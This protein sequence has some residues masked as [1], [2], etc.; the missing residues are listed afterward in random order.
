MHRVFALPLGCIALALA[1]G[2]GGPSTTTVYGK[3]TYQGKPATSGLI[4]FKADKQKPIGGGI[5]PDGSY[6]YDLPVGAYQVRIETPPQPP[7]GWKEGDPTT[8][9][10][11]RQI[12][13]KY[14]DFVGS[15]LTVTVTDDA[16]SQEVDFNLQ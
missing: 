2:C 3:I 13:E 12:P 14:G 16:G 15:G 7:A 9:M 4:N 10:G 5:Q 6:E 8:K 11:P 1:L